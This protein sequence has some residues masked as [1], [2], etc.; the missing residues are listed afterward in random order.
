MCDTA[1]GFVV[2]FVFR[3]QCGRKQEVMNVA[4]PADP[5]LERA[6]WAEHKEK[7]PKMTKPDT[8]AELS[9]FAYMS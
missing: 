9:M 3:V 6:T 5:N 1:D 7:A 8:R 4:V 2:M